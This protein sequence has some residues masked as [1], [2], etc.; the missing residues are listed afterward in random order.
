MLPLEIFIHT[1]ASNLDSRIVAAVL[2]VWKKFLYFSPSGFVA[3]GNGNP[4]IGNREKGNGLIIR[5]YNISDGNEP[6]QIVF[7]VTQQKLVQV[8]LSAVKGLEFI[9][10]CQPYKAHAVIHRSIQIANVSIA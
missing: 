5:L 1:Q 2:C 7:G 3:V 4:V 10:W 6:L 8:L 9:I